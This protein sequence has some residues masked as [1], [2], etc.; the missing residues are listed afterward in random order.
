MRSDSTW[1]PS[2]CCADAPSPQPLPPQGLERQEPGDTTQLT[3]ARALLRA[4]P[5]RPHPGRREAGSL[6]TTA[7]RSR[8][9]FNEAAA[10]LPREGL[11]DQ[12]LPQRRQRRASMRPRH[13]CRGREKFTAASAKY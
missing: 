1:L 8:P 5:L 9:S 4:P 2:P 11:R 3:P 10:L 13:Y 12:L 7:A 6:T